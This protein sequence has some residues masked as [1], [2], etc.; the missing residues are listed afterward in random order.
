[1]GRPSEPPTPFGVELRRLR[2]AAGI[3]LSDLAARLAYS[4]SH[5]SKV[6]AGIKGPS[7]DLARR[8]DV[9]L[10][11]QG[12]LVRLA[13]RTA[14]A[15]PPADEGS[16]PPPEPGPNNARPDWTTFSS[17]LRPTSDAASAEQALAAFRS[18]LESLRELGQTLGPSLIIP[19]LAPTCTALQELALRVEPDQAREALVMA[20]RFAEY[21]G[22][23][24]QEMGDDVGALRWT[25]KAVELAEIAGDNDMVAYA[26][27]RRAN[28]AMYQHDAYGTIAFSQRAQEMECSDRVRGLAAQREAQGHALAGDHDAF[29]RCMTLA[30]TLL[31][32]SS[33]EVNQRPVLGS[34][35]MPDI[36]ALATGWSL[37]DLGRPAEAVEVLDPLFERTPKK[38]SRAWARIGARLAL[39]LASGGEVDRACAVTQPILVLFPVI[40]SATIRSDLRQLAR[41][42]NRWNSN[43]SV[44]RIMPDLSAALTPAAKT[45]SRSLNP[46]SGV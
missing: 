44:R 35:K 46:A 21:A 26:F 41:V 8:C 40:E 31:S 3:S 43:P 28:I 37:Y 42:L 5:L 17:W 45:E 23:M 29:Q 9:A 34:T 20:A 12:V 15:A 16:P 27:V 18:Q 7:A 10:N 36:I 30:A 39:S 11:A 33:P 13:R 4:K 6:E 24:V 32:A 1:M 2:I 14:T 25:D 22:W 19:I 38:A